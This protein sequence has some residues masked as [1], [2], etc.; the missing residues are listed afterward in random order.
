MYKYVYKWVHMYHK[1]VKLSYK[2]YNYVLLIS[3]YVLTIH[4]YV[5]LRSIYAIK[6]I[7]Q[8]HLAEK[9]RTKFVY[10]TGGG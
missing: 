2:T 9:N 4:K 5:F 3:I 6:N 7:K 8:C 1:F 10:K